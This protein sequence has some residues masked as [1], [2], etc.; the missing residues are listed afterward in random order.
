MSNKDSNKD[1][2]DEEEEPKLSASGTIDEILNKHGKKRK[3]NRKRFDGY[4]NP[5]VDDID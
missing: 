5:G 1:W 4:K 2:I 3:K